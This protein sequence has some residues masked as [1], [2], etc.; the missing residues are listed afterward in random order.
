M[1]TRCEWVN[2]SANRC[3][4]WTETPWWSAEDTDYSLGTNTL[5]YRYLNRHPQIY[6]SRLKT[7]SSSPSRVRT[8]TSAVSSSHAQTPKTAND[9]EAYRA[10][11]A[12]VARETAVGEASSVYFY[13][14]KGPTVTP[15]TGATGVLF[16]AQTPEA[17]CS[18]VEFIEA[19]EG[20]FDPAA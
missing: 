19:H 20:A 10:P 15:K 11:F 4:G 6:M 12:V 9:L 8:S 7:P 14:E 17:L 5:L 18:A 13:G 3:R 2:N 1:R 16:D